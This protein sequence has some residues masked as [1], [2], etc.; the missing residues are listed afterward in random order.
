M[1]ISTVIAHIVPKP[2]NCDTVYT[3][4]RKELK[5]RD[6]IMVRSEAI[7]YGFHALGKL[8][9]VNRKCEHAI[10][11]SDNAKLRISFSCVFSFPSSDKRIKIDEAF[12]R[13]PTID[14]MRSMTLIYLLSSVA[15]SKLK[16]KL[17]T[18]LALS[19]EVLVE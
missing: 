2:A 13:I 17:C 16:S 6:R 15:I 12:N 1:N 19:N 10:K 8:Y 4:A 3:N 18:E 11:P 7:L 5:I 14:I 9:T